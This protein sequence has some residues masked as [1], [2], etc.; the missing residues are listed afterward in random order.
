MRAHGE[1]ANRIVARANLIKPKLSYHCLQ[2]GWRGEQ[3]RRP[4]MS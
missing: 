2:R 4:E 3:G 1:L